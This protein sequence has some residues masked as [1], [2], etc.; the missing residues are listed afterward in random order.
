MRKLTCY[1]WGKPGHWEALCVDY[2]IPAQGDSFEDVRPELADAVGTYL[3]Y[4]SDLPENE[5]RAFLS[6]KAPLSLR[7]RL[8]L[9]SRISRTLSAAKLTSDVKGVARARFVVTPT[10]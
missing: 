6:R 7:L 8:A 3:D 10:A 1:A 2:D 4:V 9:A 5:Q